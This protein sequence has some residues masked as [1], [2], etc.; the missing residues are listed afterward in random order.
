MPIPIYRTQS[1]PII[2]PNPINQQ[3]IAPNSQLAFSG[4]TADFDSRGWSVAEPSDSGP[5]PNAD[6]ENAQ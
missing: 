3:S 1:N 5:T 2:N 4:G 6:E